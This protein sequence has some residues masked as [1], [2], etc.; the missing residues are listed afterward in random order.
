M[1]K[2]LISDCMQ[3]SIKPK[4]VFMV[5]FTEIVEKQ[6]KLLLELVPEWISEKLASGRDLLLIK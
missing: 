2:Q 5:N 3:S 4:F 1:P 6:L